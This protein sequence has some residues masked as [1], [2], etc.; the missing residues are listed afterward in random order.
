MKRGMKL[1]ALILSTLLLPVA[2]QASQWGFAINNPTTAVDPGTRQSIRTSGS[3]LFND[4][5]GTVSGSGAYSIA[6]ASGK[7]IERGTWTATF[8]V[9]FTSDG[10]PN[11]GDGKVVRMNHPDGGPHDRD[12]TVIADGLTFPTAMTFGPDG[13]LYVSNFGFGFPPDGEGQILKITVPY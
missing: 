5:A 3:G 6:D 10:G 11:P 7:V 2:A 12:Q 1:I 8:F 13:A 9:G 4:T